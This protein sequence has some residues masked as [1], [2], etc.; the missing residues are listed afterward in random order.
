MGIQDDNFDALLGLP[1]L[2]LPEVGPGSLK[3]VARVGVLERVEVVGGQA[4]VR[5]RPN[6]RIEPVP[7]EKV[8]QQRERFGVSD[9]WGLHRT[10]VVVGEGDLGLTLLE[11]G[12]AEGVVRPSRQYLKFPEGPVEPDLVV[13]MM[14]FSE[15]LKPVWEKL[16]QVVLAEGLRCERADSIFEEYS[17][18]DDVVAMLWRARIVISDFSEK[19]AN[20]FYETGIAHTLGRSSIP[21]AQ[22]MDEV[23][24]D[25]RGQRVVKYDQSQVGLQQMGLTVTKR[26]RT[27]LAKT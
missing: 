20:V 13:V 23:P 17:I 3:G 4:S 24:F 11:L 25:L 5:F 21:I 15:A 8:W 18:M 7:A 27:L 12:T 19:N 10:R 2:A 6:D 22:S 1:T 16:Q 26:I 14:P 9:E